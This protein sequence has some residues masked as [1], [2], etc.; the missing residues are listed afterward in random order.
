V[1]RRPKPAIG[2]NRRI[3]VFPSSVHSLQAHRPP[4]PAA[5]SE[6]R[7]RINSDFAKV[8]IKNRSAVSK[9]QRRDLLEPF[10]STGGQQDCRDSKRKPFRWRSPPEGFLQ[11]TSVAISRRPRVCGTL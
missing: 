8:G 11:A 9:M 3:G 1:L 5:A 6:N 2:C 7:V 4:L 10:D